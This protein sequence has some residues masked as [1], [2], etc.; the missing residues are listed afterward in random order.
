MRNL[1]QKRVAILSLIFLIVAILCAAYHYIA[2]YIRNLHYADLTIALSCI[3]AS[4]F[5]LT[6]I[7]FGIISL[8]KEKIKY[9]LVTSLIAGLLLLIL[10]LPTISMILVVFSSFIVGALSYIFV[11][12]AHQKIA[13][14]L[15]IRKENVFGKL[16]AYF[17]TLLSLAVLYNLLVISLLVVYNNAPIYQA[18]HQ[19]ESWLKE[20]SFDPLVSVFFFALATL[21][22]LFTAPFFSLIFL[23]STYIVQ[24]LEKSS[25]SAKRNRSILNIVIALA[26][27]IV[28]MIVSA[29]LSVYYFTFIA[30]AAGM[31]AFT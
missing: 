20:E 30:T 1:K 31:H 17:L 18:L 2:L 23:I 24:F 25:K 28:P 3:A 14:T 27:S 5:S 21:Y 4:I 13:K 11:G 29:I 19:K 8:R 7:M 16:F 15:R 10:A 12:K 9:S 26:L 22:L 6:T